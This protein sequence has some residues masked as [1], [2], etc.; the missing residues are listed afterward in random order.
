MNLGYRDVQEILRL[1]DEGPYD[2]LTLRTGAFELTLRRAADGLWTQET[3]TRG[4]EKEASSIGG[5]R[6]REAAPSPD[7]AAPELALRA[8]GR[9]SADLRAAGEG[10]LDIRAPMTGTF[11]RAPAPGAPPFVEPGARVERDGVVAIIEVMKLM[12][13]IPAGFPGEIREILVEDGAYVEKGQAL[14]RLRPVAA[15]GQVERGGKPE[16]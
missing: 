8:P 13:A 10:L 1:L 4:L 15:G 6:E 9:E 2:E 5:G 11:Y 14:M 3:Q 12:S 16:T 7:E